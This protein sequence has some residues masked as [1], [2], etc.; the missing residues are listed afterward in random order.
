MVGEGGT[1]R[2][3]SWLESQE[4]ALVRDGEDTDMEEIRVA[5]LSTDGLALASCVP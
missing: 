4:D 5:N 1:M 3:P 2:T